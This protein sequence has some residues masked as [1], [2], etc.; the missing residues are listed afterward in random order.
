M[1]NSTCRNRGASQ[2]WSKPVLCTCKKTQWQSSSN[3]ATSNST[4]WHLNWSECRNK[5]TLTPIKGPAFGELKGSIMGILPQDLSFLQ[6]FHIL[7]PS[8]AYLNPFIQ[9]TEKLRCSG[10]SSH[11]L[12]VQQ[13]FGISFCSIVAKMRI[14]LQSMTNVRC[15]RIFSNPLSLK[16]IALL[17]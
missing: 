1:A 12:R 8:G 3:R 9:L 4:K 5:K 7:Q 2:R 14:W 6:Y 13:H 16:C 15:P 11:S 17:F 10:N